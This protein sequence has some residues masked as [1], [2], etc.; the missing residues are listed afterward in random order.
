MV[1]LG[2]AA[3]MGV[4]PCCK[5]DAYIGWGMW[6]KGKVE[7][8]DVASGFVVIPGREGNNAVVPKQ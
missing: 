8:N 5:A 1:G 3:A 7:L 2:A 6:V 4:S